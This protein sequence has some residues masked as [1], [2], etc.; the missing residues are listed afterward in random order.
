MLL[1]PSEFLYFYY[2]QKAASQLVALEIIIWKAQHGAQ[3]TSVPLTFIENLKETY[4]DHHIMQTNPDKCDLM[5][6][7][8]AGFAKNE[9]S[10]EIANWTIQTYHAPGSRLANKPK[11]V[12]EDVKFGR[13]DYVWEKMEYIIYQ[14]QYDHP[15]G[16]GTLKLQFILTNK[17]KYPSAEN[18]SALILAAS[19]WTVELHEEIYVFDS[20][21]WVKDKNLY[22]S[23]Q[24]SSWDEVILNT[25]M[26]AN[27]IADVEGFFDNQA[28]YKKLA[29]PWKRGIILHGV[30]G[31]G[32]T[33]SIKA[34][35][36]SLSSR[37]FP[38]PSL[39]VKSFDGEC[40]GPKWAISTIFQKARKMAPCLLIFEDLDSLV[41]EKTR[42]Y[43]LNEVD[44]LESNDGILMIGST[45]HLGKL[46][47]SI[48]KRPSRFDRKYCFRVPNEEERRA[49]V[50]FWRVKL[51]KDGGDMVD[52]GEE[53][54]SLVAKMTEGFSFAYLKELFIVTLLSIARGARGAGDDGAGVEEEESESYTT[55]STS[56]PTDDGVVVEKDDSMENVLHNTQPSTDT[57]EIAERTKHQKT[58]P[59]VDIPQHLTDNIF[60]KALLVQAK[61]L[62]EEMDNTD[63]LMGGEK[64]LGSN[65]MGGPLP[66]G[67]AR[68]RAVMGTC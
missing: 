38:I 1:S 52:F 20:Q 57:E 34:L 13:W 67:M 65:G 58:L 40:H 6:Y 8:D 48:S 50:E 55:A 36:S 7:A 28:L 2:S 43:F 21:E 53:L 41:T 49:Y 19:A 22:E 64:V 59:K 66:I 56:T 27:L 32:K 30:P 42:S 35:M 9:R 61:M 23:V 29:V 18:T 68:A 16:F 3:A 46:D 54:C 47:S 33:I 39:Y 17:E 24:G 25:R 63:E 31:N 10:D 12:V 62:V 45:N 5:G 26:K 4:S 15:A 37:P 44:G 14:A 11:T 51:G 60:L